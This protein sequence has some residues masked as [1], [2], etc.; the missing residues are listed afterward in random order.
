MKFS[1]CGKMYKGENLKEI[2]RYAQQASVEGIDVWASPTMCENVPLTASTA[3]VRVAKEILADSGLK[4]ASV[5]SYFTHNPRDGWDDLR[6]GIEIAAIIEASV[7]VCGMEPGSW[8]GMDMALNAYAEY[9]RPI[10]R[11]AEEVGIRI[12]FENNSNTTIMRTTSDLLAFSAAIPSDNLGFCL[13]PTH[14]TIAQCDVAD[15]VRQ[16][17][18]RVAF[19]YGW[20]MIPGV[21]DDGN[22]FIYP[23]VDSAHH[24]PG[25]GR[26]PFDKYISALS[27][28][29]YRQRGSWIN[30]MS[31]G[32][33]EIFKSSWS[34]NRITDE[35][36]CSVEYL[37][38]LL[39]ETRRNGEESCN[40]FV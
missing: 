24:F 8:E 31:H 29:G 37:R 20:D 13:A 34:C 9:F 16:L 5:T 30:I 11:H 38:S 21:D 40:G 35:V 14:L 10:V 18:A 12:A 7:L 3:D 33:E 22:S 4:A 23:W 27:E 39:R 28:T 17:G 15:A 1:L 32:V 19:F 26:L 25:K 6:R 2:C 36:R